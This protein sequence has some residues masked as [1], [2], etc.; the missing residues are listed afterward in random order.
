MSLGPME[1][2]KVNKR[3]VIRDSET[4]EIVYT[5]PDFLRSAIVKQKL[6][7]LAEAMSYTVYSDRIKLIMEFEKN[8]KDRTWKKLQHRF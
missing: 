6:V 3:M 4:K 2:A 1:V 7:D 8:V 5:V